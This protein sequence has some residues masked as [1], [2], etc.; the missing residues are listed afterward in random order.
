MGLGR[1]S[2]VVA[3]AVLVMMTWT[4]SEASLIYRVPSD[5]DCCFTYRFT[6]SNAWFAAFLARAISP[7]PCGPGQI[8]NSD[9][10]C[11]DREDDIADRC[12]DPCE[13]FF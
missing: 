6:S 3:A 1:A 13:F 2:L 8:I 10:V 4:S 12:R 9:G 7:L 11:A 5:G